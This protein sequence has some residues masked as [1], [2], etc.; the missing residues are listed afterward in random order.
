MFKKSDAPLLVELNE[1]L[2]T[3]FNVLCSY[4]NNQVVFRDETWIDVIDWELRI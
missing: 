1:S 2:K 4:E 3:L